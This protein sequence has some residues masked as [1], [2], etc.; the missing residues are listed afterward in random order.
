ME[1]EFQSPACR[2]TYTDVY[3][4]SPGSNCLCVSIPCLSGNLYRPITK[5]VVDGVREFQSPACRGTYTDPTSRI[6]HKRND[7]CTRN[8]VPY[9]K[10]CFLILGDS[11]TIHAIP[12]I[13]INPLGLLFKPVPVKTITGAIGA[14]Q[15]ISATFL[16]SMIFGNPPNP[17]GD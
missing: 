6:I 2:G 1:E 8:P 10:L 14:I 15:I 7:F 5:M 16:F 3:T 13:P 4:Q 12:P 11:M 17:Y 9:E